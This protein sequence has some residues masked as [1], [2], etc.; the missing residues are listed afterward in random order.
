MNVTISGQEIDI[1]HRHKIDANE[2]LPLL[3]KAIGGVKEERGYYYLRRQNKPHGATGDGGYEFDL[4]E[5]SDFILT[6]MLAGNDPNAAWGMNND[7]EYDKRRE[8]RWVEVNLYNEHTPEKIVA[9]TCP[10]CGKDKKLEG[11]ICT[12]RVTLPKTCFGRLCHDMLMSYAGHSRENWH[13]EDIKLY[14]RL[15]KL[16]EKHR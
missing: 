11:C 6:P 16:A 10:D 12:V 9:R 7:R 5:C 4:T 2:L 13:P 1:G 15:E 14:E 8:A 3:K